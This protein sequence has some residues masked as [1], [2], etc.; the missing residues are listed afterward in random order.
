MFLLLACSGAYAESSPMPLLPDPENVDDR[1]FITRSN[2]SSFNDLLLA[3]VAT[4][5]REGLFVAQV[6]RKLPFRW[7]FNSAWREATIKNATIASLD[8]NFNIT[9][10][11]DNELAFGFPFGSSADINTERD[12]VAKAYKILWNVSYSEAM[13][14]DVYYGSEIVW[15]GRQAPLRSSRGLIVRNYEQAHDREEDLNNV[16]RRDLLKL[17]SPP[18][19][20]G[21]ATLSWRHKDAKEDKVWI[22]SPVLERSRE[23]LQ[24]NRSD[25]IIE[26]AL[27]FDDLFVWSSK[28]QSVFAKVV[29]EKFILVP[30]SSMR[31]ML[32]EKEEISDLPQASLLED[33]RDGIVENE[34]VENTAWSVVDLFDSPSGR[35]RSMLWNY[36]TKKFPGYAPWVPTEV[37]FAPRKVWILEIS[38]KDPYYLAGKQ[39]LVVDQ[40]T[41]LPIYKVVYNRRGGYEKTV[42]GAWAL[43]SNPDGEVVFPFS[44]FVLAVEQG[45]KPAVSVSNNYVR[46][47]LGT[48]ETPELYISAHERRE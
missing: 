43:G 9:T 46:T 3:P 33:S 1:L 48:K 31:V 30:F 27:S 11:E 40:E 14:R 21:F 38:P 44:A 2:V 42:F 18:V 37:I 16:L 26:G 29:E 36:E 5:I 35:R 41:M 20:F 13:S 34:S 24:S 28:V 19:V 45:F 10:T 17:F 22:Y 6:V 8:E 32:L 25:P 7:Q 47:F 15:I 12:S 39:V 23:V 4:W